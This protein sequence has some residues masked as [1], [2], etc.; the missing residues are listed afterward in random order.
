M[1]SGDSSTTLK[2][3][4]GSPWDGMLQKGHSRGVFSEGGVSLFEEPKQEN[5]V[6]IVGR[7]VW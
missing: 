1:N 5:M 3:E 6:G 7:V 2:D 4:L